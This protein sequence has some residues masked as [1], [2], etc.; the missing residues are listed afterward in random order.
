M[1]FVLIFAGT[2]LLVAAVRNTQGVLY[3]L[4]RNDF[5]GPNN[6]I[7]WTIAILILGAIGYIQRLKPISDAFL[8]LI[9]IVLFLRRGTGFFDSFQRQIA[10]TQTAQATG[11]LTYPGLRPISVGSVGVSLPPITISL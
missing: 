3:A 5:S 10:T 9:I 4:V 7:Y 8:I 2:I 1:P 6:F 11:S